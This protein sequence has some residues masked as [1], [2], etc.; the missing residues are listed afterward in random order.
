MLG[1]EYFD[2]ALDCKRIQP[3]NLSKFVVA[4][5]STASFMLRTGI[6]FVLS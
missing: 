6:A 1:M 2:N 4:D 5:W 3:L